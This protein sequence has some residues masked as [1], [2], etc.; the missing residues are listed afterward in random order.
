L[1]AR[2]AQLGELLRARQHELGVAPARRPGRPGGHPVVPVGR[3]R[4]ADAVAAA[5]EPPAD[6]FLADH[7]VALVVSGRVGVCSAARPREIA[8][9]YSATWRSRSCGV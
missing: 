5:V 6:G 2:L 7:A 8:A 9:R 4:L 1:E 3:R